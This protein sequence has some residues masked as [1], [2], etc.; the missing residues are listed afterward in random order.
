MDWDN[1][2]F[3]V[4]IVALT[5]YKFSFK[6]KISPLSELGLGYIFTDKSGICHAV[7]IPVAEHSLSLPFQCFVFDT[8]SA[9]TQINLAPQFDKI[10]K[11]RTVSNSIVMHCIQ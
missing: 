3:V 5:T 2:F 4:S 9:Y 8:K 7:P 1:R 11:G 10:W 6:A